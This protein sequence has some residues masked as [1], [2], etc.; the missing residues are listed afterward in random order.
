MNMSATFLQKRYYTEKISSFLTPSI[1][2]VVLSLFTLLPN[3][4][5]SQDSQ[6][7][8]IIIEGNKRIE[9]STILSIAN[10]TKENIY[11][12][13][14]I[15]KSLILLKE[16]TYFKSVE[17]YNDN[18]VLYITVKENPTINSISFEGNSFL[19]DENL[20][21]LISLSERKTLLLSVIENDAEKIA[22][23][24]VSSG[25]IAAVI[26]PKIIERDDNRV[27][28]IFEVIEGSVTEIEKIT[29]IGNR[30]FSDFRLRGIIATKQAGI[31]RG[32]FKSDT[33]IEDR[34]NYDK[35]LLQDFYINRGYMD[36]EVI[37]V[38]TTMTREKDGFLLNFSIKEG[39]RYE[40]SDVKFISDEKYIDLTE[41]QD[42]NNI[43]IGDRY[44]PR[45]VDDLISRVNNKLSKG[46]IDF[47][48]VIPQITRNDQS[49]SI[50]VKLN[51]LKSKKI[52][53]ERIEITGNSTTLDEVIRRKFDFVEGD[54]FNRIKLQRAIDRVRGLGFFNDVQV[55]TSVGSTS[56]KIII[57]LI[58]DEKP[59][60]SLGIGAGY[61]SSDGSV[62]TFNINE[63]NFLG[64]GQTLDLALSSSSI[65]REMTVGF[66]DPSFLGRN[67]L[68]GISFGRKTSTPYAVPLK[69]D[70]TFIAPKFR[71]PLSKDSTLTAI[72]KIDKD[73]IKLHSSSTITSPI[74]NS[75]VGN[76]IKSGVIL[77]YD[78]D[79]TNSVVTPTSGFKVFVQQELNGFAGD[80]EFSKTTAGIKSFKSFFNGELILSSSASSGFILGSGANVLDRFSLGGD[81]LRGFRNY[82]IGPIDNSYTGSDSNGDPL[83]GNM[84]STI[85]LEASFPIGIPE[86]YGVFGGIFVGAGSVWGLDQTLSGSSVIDDTAKIRAAAGVS[87]FWDTVIGP[88]RFNFSRPI[89]KETYDITEN[90]RFTVD[91]RF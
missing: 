9:T 34:I 66:E 91:T 32:F 77:K 45:R 79:K 7:N 74:I 44:D 30:I 18:G 68:A 43:N 35:Q 63:R 39:Q 49:N 51:L 40:Y 2:I 72:Y 54:P 23:A 65:E 88:L 53:I 31:F 67:L 21:G 58:L 71:F 59:T 5:S 80:V 48:N 27:D 50:N 57:K 41:I 55:K 42:L 47:I 38:T 17:L 81:S 36:F 52:F 84:F 69:V 75:D 83:G 4:S 28:L 90:F 56:E 86:E 46:D 10:I 8:N 87:L 33:Y 22:N 6:I 3:V 19:S 11:S 37:S 25:R 15:N 89:A 29:F 76:N 14:D 12:A 70:N 24:Y 13:D 78:I 26:T 62:L 60:G 61:N 20:L 85:N 1:F 64:K 82:G 73:D 16:S